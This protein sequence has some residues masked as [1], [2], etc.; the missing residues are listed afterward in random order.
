MTANMVPVWSITKSNVIGG[1]DG[2]RPISFSA[3]TTWAEL[4][5]GS[6]SANPCTIARMMTLTT[7]IDDL[8]QMSGS[9]GYQRGRTDAVV[10]TVWRYRLPT[11]DSSAWYYR[12][13]PKRCI[14]DASGGGNGPSS[15]AATCERCASDAVNTRA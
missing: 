1:D 14:T 13:P 11:R 8:F 9:R 6:S 15:C 4:E 10:S 5:T 7:G 12:I 3:T 2:S